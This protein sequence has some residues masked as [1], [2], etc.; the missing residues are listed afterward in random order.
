MYVC[1]QLSVCKAYSHYDDFDYDD[2]FELVSDM[3]LLK[4]SFLCSIVHG[5]P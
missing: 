3:Y 2:V 5:R 4:S 1:I